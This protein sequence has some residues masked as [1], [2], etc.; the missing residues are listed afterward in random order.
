MDRTHPSRPARFLP[1]TSIAVQ[2]FA[3]EACEDVIFGVETRRHKQRRREDT[4]GFSGVITASTASTRLQWCK[5]SN[6][7]QFMRCPHWILQISA[8]FSRAHTGTPEI[9]TKTQTTAPTPYRHSS[10]APSCLGFFRVSSLRFTLWGPSWFSAWDPLGFRVLGLFW[11]YNSTG[12]GL[13]QGL[14][15]FGD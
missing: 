7:P 14:G 11:D 13:A 10:A 6:S 3:G 2:G 8:S 12:F 15:F 9:R 1:F 4:P 5:P